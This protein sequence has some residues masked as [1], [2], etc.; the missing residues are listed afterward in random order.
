M[1][2]DK[3]FT[4]LFASLRTA[5]YVWEALAPDRLAALER[6][7]GEGLSPLV[8]RL[9]L[10]KEEALPELPPGLDAEVGPL[11]VSTLG[12]Y[13][14]PH[15]PWT[16]AEEA[17]YLSA[18]SMALAR[19]LVEK[20][21]HFRNR[22]VL[23]LGSGAG[24]L[25]LALSEVATEVRGL[26]SSARAVA[27]ASASARAQGLSR[28][29]FVHAHIGTAEADRAAE[30][31]GRWDAA[32]F[33][34]PMAI[35]SSAPRPQRDGGSLGIEI[36][37]VFLEFA[38]RQLKP[39]GEVFCLATNPIRA[40]KS[41]LLERIPSETWEIVEKR[42]LHDDFNRSLHRQ[43]GYARLGVERVELWFLHCCK[44]K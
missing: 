38:G 18:E 39:G 34:P 11:R 28:L 6:T 24:V 19:I 26:E 5:G 12:S 44:R 3:T 15:T 22:R 8:R 17:V 7:G 33:N 40:G 14:I 20:S 13:F 31:A 21:E 32:V 1:S 9:G 23:D 4:Q 41:A 37:L 30:P 27:W 29:H 25:S 10:G 2:L 42:R 35:P 16:V 36:P 43:D